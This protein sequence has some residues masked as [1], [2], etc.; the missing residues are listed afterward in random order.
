MVLTSNANCA[1]TNTATSNK[2]IITITPTVIPAVSI[3]AGANPIC[4]GSSVTFTASPING[5]ASPT[6]QWYKNGVFQSGNTGT[7]TSSAVANN[8]SIWSIMTSNAQ[9][10]SPATATSNKVYMTVNP[11]VTPTVSITA[12]KNPLCAGDSVTFTATITN[13]G[14]NPAYQWK[15]NNLNV[16]SNSAIYGTTTLASNDSVWCVLTSNAPVLH[17]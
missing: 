7:Y 5:G 6:Y 11:I 9:C 2:V 10:P 15:K 16:G 17:R 13:G 8:D 14:A 1:S 12:S 3:S 4:A